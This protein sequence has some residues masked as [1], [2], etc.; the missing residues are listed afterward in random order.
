MYKKCRLLIALV[1]VLLIYEYSRISSENGRVDQDGEFN[2]PTNKVRVY[3]DSE[4][5]LNGNVLQ[6]SSIVIVNGSILEIDSLVVI[7]ESD[8]SHKDLMCLVYQPSTSKDRSMVYSIDSS[9]SIRLYDSMFNVKCATNEIDWINGQL[10]VAIVSTKSTR[11]SKTLFTQIARVFEKGRPKLKSVYLCSILNDEPSYYELSQWILLNKYL[12]IGQIKLT[13]TSISQFETGLVN[14]LL[15]QNKGYLQARLIKQDVNEFCALFDSTNCVEQFGKMFTDSFHLQVVIYNECLLIARNN[16]EY[17]ANYD[18]G[19]EL[20]F[21][22]RFR[23]DYPQ[24]ALNHLRVNYT[25]DCNSFYKDHQTELMRTNTEHDSMYEYV[26]RLIKVQNVDDTKLG[27]FYFKRFQMSDS[28]FESISL[29]RNLST[30]LVEVNKLPT[31]I[32]SKW[33]HL[34]LVDTNQPIG[35]SLFKTDSVLSITRHNAF[36]LKPGKEKI[37][38]RTE[39]GHVGLFSDDFNE[40]GHELD[41]ELLYYLVKLFSRTI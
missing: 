15:K 21:P 41:L 34:F 39:F 27:Y 5:I 7:T 26:Q 36:L 17:M 37:A 10:S 25:T 12:G 18:P 14:K 3:N 38:V 40:K 2:L 20:I 19:S 4:W 29:L 28:A 35:K 32:E 22:R 33:T 16:Y 8:I 30:C 9:E 31:R 23:T 13:A 11:S 24:L 6:Y 1:I